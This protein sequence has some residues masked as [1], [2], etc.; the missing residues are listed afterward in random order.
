LFVAHS[1]SRAGDAFNTV[2]LVVLVFRLTGSGVGVAAIVAFEIAPVLLFGPVAG[3][4]ADRLPRRGI[5]VGAD[6]ARAALAGLLAATHGSLAVV[7]LV[8]SGLSAGSVAF[9][10][11]AA[12]VVPD[13]VAGEE[14]VDA[15]A[16]LWTTAVVAQIVLAPTAGVVISAFGIGAAFAI[17]AA[18]FV[19]S[20]LILRGLAVARGPAASGEHGWRSV[21]AGWTVV[22]ADPLLGRLAVVQVL[23]ALSA[24]ATSGLLVVLAS[25]RLH[26]GPSGFG[27][28]LAAIGVGAALGP[29]LLRRFI[30]PAQPGWLFGPYALRGTVDL[31]LA[32]THSPV[33]AGGAL[34]L[35]GVGTS[36]GTVAY[37]STLQAVV[38]PAARGRTFALF[39]VLWQAARLFSLAAGGVIADAAGIRSVYAI[40]GVLLLLAFTVGITRL[41]VHNA[42]PPSPA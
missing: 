23:A 36:T 20:A 31:T 28:L 34:G 5:M 7:F 37:Q 30:R 25:Q 13:T 6:L 32:V 22:R 1:V 29:P 42:T 27:M 4:L 14:L 16:A 19:A 3:L 8:A 41:P 24:G 11:A 38:P 39:D 12:A 33:V 17:N 18:S 21:A 10:P 26:V 35:Y 2:A 15:N 9:N 40:G